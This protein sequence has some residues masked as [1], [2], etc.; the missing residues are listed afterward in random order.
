GNALFDQHGLEYTRRSALVLV[1]LAPQ[2]VKEFH[3]IPFSIDVPDSRIVEAGQADAQIIM[4][5]FK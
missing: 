5:Y 1:T 3:A 4:Q 2:G